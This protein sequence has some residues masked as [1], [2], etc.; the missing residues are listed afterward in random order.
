[1]SL[2]RT[3]AMRCYDEEWALILWADKQWGI[4]WAGLDSL[5]WQLISVKLLLHNS[6]FLHSLKTTFSRLSGVRD[7][8]QNNRCK[9][10]NTWIKFV[11]ILDSFYIE[12]VCS[13]E[14][15]NIYAKRKF[16]YRFAKPWILKFWSSPNQKPK[17]QNV[18]KSETE[19]WG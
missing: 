17:D 5:T 4:F 18:L 16:Y 11:Y 13:P 2:R 8:F 14:T 3:H 10:S 7:N 1:M 15:F 9:Q 12:V 19:A 6:S